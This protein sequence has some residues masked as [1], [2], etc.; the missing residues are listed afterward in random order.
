M[1]KMTTIIL[2]KIYCAQK[3]SVLFFGLVN[4]TF[5]SIYDI[6]FM[7][8]KEISNKKK[9]GENN[10]IVYTVLYSRSYCSEYNK[11]LCL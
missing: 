8:I 9:G 6:I 5:S 10:G 2:I 4:L 1:Y 11:R 7:E 3:H